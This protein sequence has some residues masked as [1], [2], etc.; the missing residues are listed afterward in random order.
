MFLSFGCVDISKMDTFTI[1]MKTV[2]ITFI[3]ILFAF[4]FKIFAEPSYRK[5]L[6]EDVVVTQSVDNI[7]SRRSPA[8]TICPQEVWAYEC[9]LHNSNERCQALVTRVG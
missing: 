1:F 9:N 5:W 2:K 8:I 6:K 3:V 7:G 4:F